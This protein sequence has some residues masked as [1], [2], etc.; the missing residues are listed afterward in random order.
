ML[1]TIS[2]K[3]GQA[4][5][6]LAI[7][8]MLILMAFSYV[9]NFGQSLNASQQV[10]QEAFRKA[11]Q[12]AWLTNSNVEFSQKRNSRAA[13]T[14]GSFFQG[15]AVSQQASAKVMWQKGVSGPQGMDDVG[16]FAYWNINDAI[17]SGQDEYGLPRYEKKVV[18]LDGSEQY[19]MIPSSVYKENATRTETYSLDSI[20]QEDASGITYNKTATM[21]DNSSGTG[22]AHYDTAVDDDP[23]DDDTPTP[24]YSSAT[25][26][27]YGG[28]GETGDTYQYSKQWR[29][30]HNNPTPGGED[31]DI[32]HGRS[33]V[34]LPVW[35]SMYPGY[36]YP[37]WL[38]YSCLYASHPWVITNWSNGDGYCN[39]SVT[40]ETVAGY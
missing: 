20:K 29:V 18:S 16:G 17:P 26:H 28:S 8:G 4:A 10:K 39:W 40:V 25:T 11:L 37:R 30:E 6:E 34:S 2:N 3:N 23:W 33:I 15:Q 1:K 22:Y 19:L 27:T 7:L 31:A 36:N 24:V 32:T 5:A 9:M 13:S 35:D 14:S 12:K 21:E 38:V